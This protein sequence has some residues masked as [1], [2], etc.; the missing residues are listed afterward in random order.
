[1]KYI[2]NNYI[3]IL[4]EAFYG[5]GRFTWG[6]SGYLPGDFDYIVLNLKNQ[7]FKFQ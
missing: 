6:F 7:I 2:L 3:R 4:L 5:L 1:M